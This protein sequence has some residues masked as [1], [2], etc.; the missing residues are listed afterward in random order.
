MFKKNHVG[1]PSNEELKLRRNKKIIM[2]LIPVVFLV[3]IVLTFMSGSFKNLMGNS[4]IQFECENGSK[5][6]E[7]N[8]NQVCK[9]S[10]N[11]ILLGDANLDGKL[12]S[13]DIILMQKVVSDDLKINEYQ[14]AAADI[15]KNDN[16]ESLDIELLTKYLNG[17]EVISTYKTYNL[18]TEKTCIKGYQL[19]DNKCVTTVD[20]KRVERFETVYGDVNLDG[21]VNETDLDYLKKNLAKYSG[22]NLTAQ[23]K[24]NAD[25][26]IDGQIDAKD[27]MILERYLNKMTGYE[28][29][30]YKGKIEETENLKSAVYGDVNN[31][32]K[33]NET[34]LDYLTKNLAKYSG[35]DLT[36]QGKINADV[37][38]DGQIDS[39][40]RMILAR[41][42]NKMTGYGELPYKGKIEETENL[43]SAV[44]GDVNL[45]GK[46]NE[47]DLDYLTKYL[48]N[49]SGYALTEQG[50][51]NADLNADD[52]VDAKDRMILSRYLGKEEAQIFTIKYDGNGGTGKMNDQTITFGV[53]TKLT[54]N[55]YTK[56][57]YSFTGW[58]AYNNNKKQW[59]CYKNSEKT[60]QGYVSQ[61]V[62]NKYGYVVYKDQQ[63]VFKTGDA[64]EVITMYAQWKWAEPKKAVT[65][66]FTPETSSTTVYS[67]RKYKIKINLNLNDK[68]NS[69][70]YKWITYKDGKLNY[71]GECRKVSTK[72]MTYTLDIMAKRY[73]QIAIYSDKSC[74]KKITSYN[75]KTYNLSSVIWPVTPQF[76]LLE[77]DKMV[78][79]YKHYAYGI[80]EGHEGLDITIPVGTPVY[81]ISDGTICSTY[82]GNGVNNDEDYG[83]ALIQ[84]TK[85]NGKSYRIIYAHLKNF[86]VKSGKVTKGQLIAYSGMTGGTRIPHVHIDIRNT[87]S[88]SINSGSRVNPLNILP[89]INNFK[90]LKSSVSRSDY[91]KT[92]FSDSSIDLYN[93]MYKAQKSGSIWNYKIYGRVKTNYKVSSSLTLKKGTIVEL[94][95]RTRYKRYQLKIKYNNKTYSNL[96]E[97]Y[98]EFVWNN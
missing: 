38:I 39:K 57:N 55:S 5:P 58:R 82:S 65:V 63:T 94:V 24:I 51:I 10:E 42:L 64:G 41:Y 93:R 43:K 78:T 23:G 21:K 85:I 48:A 19:T 92:E 77:H 17:E 81:A 61:D 12:D 72:N 69:Y 2:V 46:V 52:K 29:L 62:C 22:Y 30:P 35:Y 60:S 7:Q 88:C 34:D 73:G 13:N 20:A 89:N 98:F 14:F 26:N 15:N 59:A 3:A 71:T 31:D 37:N 45:D 79:R 67:R 4:V 25:V 70:Y 80:S 83:N 28:E 16:I 8:G 36:E 33:I 76:Q 96:D 91:T 95:S 84:T 97:T 66:K 74:S 11:A 68:N 18:G 27:R 50:K 90:N 1:R 75:T 87:S 56:S 86:V 32:G 49:Y 53:K 54:K 6:F 44:Y 47:T 40:D 9:V